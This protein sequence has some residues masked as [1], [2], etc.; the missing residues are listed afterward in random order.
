M[1]F[2]LFN[3]KTMIEDYDWKIRNSPFHNF[4]GMVMTAINCFLS[5]TLEAEKL[6]F[7][8]Y[9]KLFCNKCYAERNSEWRNIYAKI[10]CQFR[11][12]Y[13]NKTLPSDDSQDFVP[14]YE[15]QTKPETVECNAA[16]YCELIKLMGKL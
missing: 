5:I 2:N 3:A 15:L 1:S 13:F 12:F 8:I 7:V 16:A 11:A 14:P 6:E 9:F 10:Y 4:F